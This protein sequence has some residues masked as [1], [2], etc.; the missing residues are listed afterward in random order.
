MDFLWKSQSAW[1]LIFVPLAHSWSSQKLQ[2]CHYSEPPP[3]PETSSFSMATAPRPRRS[4]RPM[5]RGDSAFNPRVQQASS[6]ESLKNEPGGGVRLL[7]YS[8]H[9][10]YV[11]QLC[12]A[13]RGKMW[14][15]IVDWLCSQNDISVLVNT[16]YIYI[17]G[18]LKH[19][20]VVLS[21]YLCFMLLLCSTS[22]ASSMLY[23]NFN[24]WVSVHTF[25]VC[26]R[27]RAT[28][29]NHCAITYYTDKLLKQTGTVVMYLSTTIT[30]PH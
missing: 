6:A 21:T 16:Q 5:K 13:L 4:T 26:S 11:P 27:E 8:L 18:L 28:T 25:S 24:I 30:P 3:T 7:R 9:S 10:K 19:D 12:T 20:S 14:R 1:S 29:D 23:S 22:L 2:Q 17:N 15:H